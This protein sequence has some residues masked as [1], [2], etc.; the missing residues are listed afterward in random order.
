MGALDVW[1]GEWAGRV[2]WGIQGL[3]LVPEAP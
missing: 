1:L 2:P 3:E